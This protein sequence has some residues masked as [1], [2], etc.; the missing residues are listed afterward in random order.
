[1]GN[2]VKIDNSCNRCGWFS[3]EHADWPAWDGTLHDDVTHSAA[4]AEAML[5]QAME[6]SEAALAAKVAEHAEA[7]DKLEALRV[8]GEADQREVV[9]QRKLA[10][11]WKLE[12]TRASDEL[13]D[14]KA[15]ERRRQREAQAAA[16]AC[17]AER[18]VLALLGS[19]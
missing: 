13:A 9:R 19:E 16:V 5:T 15:K 8:A 11:Q 3:P 12:S 2:G 10:E 14:L 1:M 17:M 7:A 4:E 6:A 18:R